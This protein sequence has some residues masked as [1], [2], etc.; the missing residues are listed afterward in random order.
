MT[1]QAVLKNKFSES[2]VKPCQTATAKLLT[3]SQ[4]ALPFSWTTLINKNSQ[5]PFIPVCVCVCVWVYSVIQPCLILWDP[6]N[7]S[8][9]ASSVLE[10]SQAI[11]LE[12]EG[13]VPRR[14]KYRMGRPLSPPQIN[15]KI[16]W[17]LNLQLPQNNFWMLSE[18]TRH[19]ERQPILFKRR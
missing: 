10:I 4:L 15:Q 11:I 18:D 3:P 16:I 5:N 6:M 12:L 7:C 2:K 19:P 14:Q 1:F 13:M 9:P 8:P 17:M